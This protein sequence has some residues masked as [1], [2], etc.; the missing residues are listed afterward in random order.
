MT[1]LS[2]AITGKGYLLLLFF[3]TLL[4]ALLPSVPFCPASGPNADKPPRVPSLT[5]FTAVRMGGEAREVQKFQNDWAKMASRHDPEKAF[6]KSITAMTA[7]VL[8]QWNNLSKLMPSWTPE[9]KLQNING[10]FNRWDSKDDQ[11]NYGMEEYWASPEEFLE[12]GGDCEDY[13]IIKYMALRYFGWPEEDLWILLAKDKKTGDHHAA[14]AARTREKTFILDNLSRPVYLLIPEAQY[15]RNFTPLYAIN[16]RGAW[17]MV[18]PGGGSGDG[19]SPADTR[20]VCGSE[21]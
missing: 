7:P 15:V 20:P 2:R 18:I 14:L 13:A 3:A 19:K 8:A 17:M 11:S 1:V 21:L 10:F 9:K 12:N 5:G 6:G 16:G 4:L